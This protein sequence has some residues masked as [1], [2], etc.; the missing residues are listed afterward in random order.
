MKVKTWQSF[1][2]VSVLYTILIY[3]R[4][5]QDFF[6]LSCRGWRNHQY[7]WRALLALTLWKRKSMK[8]WHFYKIQGHF[9]R[10]VL[11]HLGYDL[12]WRFFNISR[13][14]C[15]FSFFIYIYT[16]FTKSLQT[17]CLSIFSFLIWCSQFFFSFNQR[18]LEITETC[19]SN[20]ICLVQLRVRT[21]MGFYLN[22]LSF[23]LLLPFPVTRNGKN[24][25]T[26]FHPLLHA[27]FIH[28]IKLRK[29]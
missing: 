20:P 24:C 25:G 28:N 11:G 22:S 3:R 1:F 5:L 10:W 8:L 29:L 26:F 13:H 27:S 4:K 14:R 7:H 23:T 6:S 12:A 17:F 16:L 19:S 21:T 9:K 2:S 18:N 15:L